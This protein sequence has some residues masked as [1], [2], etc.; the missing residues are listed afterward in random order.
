MGGA[1]SAA[2]SGGLGHRLAPHHAAH[3]QGSPGPIVCPFQLATPSQSA[4][5]RALHK[6]FLWGHMQRREFITLLGG[7]ASLPLAARAQQAPMPVIGYLGVGD[8]SGAKD[9]VDGFHSGLREMGFVEGQ[10]VAIEFRWA[11]GRLERLPE[12]AADLVHRRV[13]VICTTSNVATLAVKRATSEIPLV[14]VVGLDPVLMGLVPAIGRPGGN[15]T[16]VSFLTSGST[17]TF[18]SLF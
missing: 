13:A 10:N 2:G 6:R 3:R 15:A 16:G 9:V 1:A 4:R 18:P 14:F 5:L 17:L 11:E 12:L 7:A 8:R